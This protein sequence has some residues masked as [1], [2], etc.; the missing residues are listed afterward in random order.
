MADPLSIAASVLAIATA[1][2]KTS[3]S[4]YTLSETVTTASQRVESIAS[5]V[6][7]TVSILNQLRDLIIPEHGPH[8]TRTTIF[9]STALRDI[10]TAIR[11]CQHVFKQIHRYL[12]R[13]TKQIKAQSLTPTTKIQLSTSEKA[14]WPFLQ[15]QF[16]ELRNDLRDSKSNLLLMVTVAHLAITQK[17]GRRRNIN[18]EEE[19]ELRTTIIRLQRTEAAEVQS[20]ISDLSEE[21]ISTMKRL[22]RKVRGLR[23][24]KDGKETPKPPTRSL[25]KKAEEGSRDVAV[26]PKTASSNF[27]EVPE[28]EELPVVSGS[29]RKTQKRVVSR[30]RKSS[31]SSVQQ[32]QPHLADEEPD[33]VPEKRSS[34]YKV[35]LDRGAEDVTSVKQKPVELQAESVTKMPEDRPDSQVPVD[36]P[37][38]ALET[39]M[40]SATIGAKLVPSTSTPETKDRHSVGKSDSASPGPLQKSHPALIENPDSIAQ[41][42]PKLDS[43]SDT[44][45]LARLIGEELMAAFEENNRQKEI[46]EDVE[47]QEEVQDEDEPLHAWVSNYSG[48]LNAEVLPLPIS[49]ADIQS[50][51]DNR[52]GEDYSL[53]GAL[54]K[55]NTI[56]RRMI[57]QQVKRLELTLYFVDTW[58]KENVSTSFGDL[59]I[60]LVL[61]VA[62]GHPRYGLPPAAGGRNRIM[63]GIPQQMMQN[64][65]ASYPG[66]LPPLQS[67]SHPPIQ[68]H[69]Q[70]RAHSWAPAPQSFPGPNMGATMPN[71]HMVGAPT[72]PPPPPPMPG[73]GAPIDY[74]SAS[75]FKKQKKFKMHRSLSESSL[76]SESSWGDESEDSSFVN[77]EDDD[78]IDAGRRE[79]GRQRQFKKPKKSQ[80]QRSLSKARGTN[81]RRSHSR[82]R[83]PIVDR[84]TKKAS[85]R[86]RDS[87][88]MVEDCFD[89]YSSTSSATTWNPEISAPPRRFGMALRAKTVKS[90]ERR[91]RQSE[92]VAKTRREDDAVVDNL[93][94][95]WTS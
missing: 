1:G 33:T 72:P 21:D 64:Q 35:A 32:T 81:R 39:S 38:I 86:P 25:G 45:E 47:I 44:K 28:N 70:T 57:L 16:T 61:W 6:G 93:L 11:H 88:P 90:K 67:Q 83:K 3:V 59:E 18:E 5:D 34:N 52:K 4:L 19:A 85:Q 14:K 30:N 46:P 8:G 71:R 73:H 2:Y 75:Q 27:Q 15:P 74:V 26:S 7:S 54:S 82:S 9:N 22:L 50:L 13:A 69:G 31:D 55:L 66:Q 77:I 53:L 43:S 40:E 95:K 68:G 41:P 91:Q 92:A 89:G 84:Y 36:V 29:R 79:R 23:P 60:V 24:S 56:Q 94:A 49:E 58:A 20:I 63:P 37:K 48:N 78:R 51:I 12:Q 65:Q 17:G 10:S 42:I 80:K 62:K 76:E 87:E